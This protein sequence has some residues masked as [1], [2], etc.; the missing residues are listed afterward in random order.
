ME[1]IINNTVSKFLEYQ[2]SSTCRKH[3]HENINEYMY[4]YIPIT[5]E[6]MNVT[7]LA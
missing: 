1:R 6:T 4:I 5:S 3:V 2:Y 7:D